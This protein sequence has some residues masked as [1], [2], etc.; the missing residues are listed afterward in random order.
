MTDSK[1][2]PDVT[3]L[4]ATA[5]QGKGRAS[6]VAVVEPPG[7]APLF[8]ATVQSHDEVTLAAS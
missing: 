2:G 8:Q 4:V 6:L 7:E 1:I 5:L 3:E